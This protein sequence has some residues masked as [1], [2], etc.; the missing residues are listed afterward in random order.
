MIR[1]LPS[2]DSAPLA[3]QSSGH[4]ARQQRPGTMQESPGR[5]NRSRG[6]KP[7]AGV[8]FFSFGGV[9]VRSALSLS[10]VPGPRDPRLGLPLARG[11]SCGQ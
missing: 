9:T 3:T 4:R 7:L 8:R 10:L 6:F 11:Y 2:S 5:S 1:L